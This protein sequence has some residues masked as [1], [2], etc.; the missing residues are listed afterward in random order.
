MGNLGGTIERVRTRSD[1]LARS[2]HDVAVFAERLTHLLQSVLPHSAACVVTVDPATGLLTG[3]YKFG[4]LSGEH[5]MDNQWAQLEYG[6]DDPSRM[7]VIARSV[8]PALATSQLAGGV[9]DSV[10]MR[11]LVMPAGYGDELRMVARSD[12]LPWGGVNLFRDQD[13]KPFG[14]DEVLM[15]GALSETVANGLRSGLMS[16][17]AADI[18]QEVP[19]GP[20]V[21]I[22]GEDSSLHRIGMGTEELLQELTDEANRSPVESMVQGLVAAARGFAVGGG[23]RLPRARLRSP[24][25]RWWI[26]QAA[27][28]A[29]RDEATG[30]VV[31]T[32]DEARPPE[33]VPLLAAAFGLTTREREV[34]QLVLG[35]VDTKGIASALSM[36]A[37]TVQDHLKSVFEKAD[38]RS[39][40]EL[41]ARVF[42]DQYAPR[43]TEEVSP[44]GWFRPDPVAPVTA[45]S[46]QSV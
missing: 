32:I 14:P 11:D 8:V 41:M 27:P 40:R 1:D 4:R 12:S 16:R 13:E 25:G 33:I 34:T 15:L 24:S 42:F 26:A 9:A 45:A 17:S 10:R 43:L 23:D 21:L 29:G 38:V 30:E 18:D 36:S 19:R 44:S 39:R 5:A 37:Y 46:P 6:T 2:G 31:I 20:A 35:G 28:L 3:T 7:A 22:V